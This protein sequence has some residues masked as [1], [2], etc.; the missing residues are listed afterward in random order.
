MTSFVPSGF[1]PASRAVAAAIV[2]RVP[3]G[4]SVVAS[5]SSSMV[6]PTRALRTGHA[7]NC[8]VPASVHE[9]PS[10][11]P[12]SDVSSDTSPAGGRVEEQQRPLGV[13][14]GGD[15]LT[16]GAVDERGA[17]LTA[18]CDLSELADRERRR[19]G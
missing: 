16:V 9:P 3:I 2:I 11:R 12:V 1:A 6:G 13:T 7:Q 8:D 18:L 19:R 14:H 17:D 5:Q 15:G 4:S 10:S